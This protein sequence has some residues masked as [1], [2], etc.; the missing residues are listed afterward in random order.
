M[1]IWHDQI[2]HLC[3]VTC[4]N[5]EECDVIDHFCSSMELKIILNFSY[6]EKSYNASRVFA[7]DRCFGNK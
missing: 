7:R 3:S 4:L 1:F 6:P 5:F 2:D